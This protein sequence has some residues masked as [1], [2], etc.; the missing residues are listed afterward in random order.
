MYVCMYVCLYGAV[1][2]QEMARAGRVTRLKLFLPKLHFL[3]LDTGLLLKARELL[4][5]CSLMSKPDDHFLVFGED[6]KE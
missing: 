4:V 5:E 6:I 2:W 3:S 1:L